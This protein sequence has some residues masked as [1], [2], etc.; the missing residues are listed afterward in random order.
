MTPIREYYNTMMAISQEV[1]ASHLH[2]IASLRELGEILGKRTESKLLMIAVAPTIQTE[3]RD[4]DSLNDDES[5]GIYLLK[6]LSLRDSNDAR[7]EALELC[8]KAVNNARAY[9]LEKE[10]SACLPFG[11]LDYES[12][13]IE[14]ESDLPGYYGYSLAFSFTNSL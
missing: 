4:K 2:M 1:K 14:V 6:S 9:M 3:G 10:G 13:S 8:Q 5:C 12:I 7:L 11:R